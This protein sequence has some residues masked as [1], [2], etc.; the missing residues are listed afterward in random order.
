[1]T[2]ISHPQ[3]FDDLRIDWDEK[4]PFDGMLFLDFSV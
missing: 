2:L 3:A 1:M 4:L